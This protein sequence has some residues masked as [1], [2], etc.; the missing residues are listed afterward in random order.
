MKI[1]VGLG[2][3]GEVYKTTRHNVGFFLIDQFCS[4]L[5]EKALEKVDFKEER[6]FKAEIA[7]FSNFVLVKPQTFMNRSGEAV[8]EIMRFYKIDSGDLC[9][10]HDDLDIGL[11]EYKIQNGVGP[12]VHNGV[13]SVEKE[14]GKKDFWRVRVGIDNRSPEL[15]KMISGEDYVLGKMSEEEQLVMVKIGDE[16]MAEMQLKLI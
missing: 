13:N 6:K 4:H 5:N 8:S 7:R 12:K 3:P 16:I 15:R 1:I 10:I 14:L 9:V 11:G 2:N